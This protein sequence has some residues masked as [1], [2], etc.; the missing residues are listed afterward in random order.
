MAL[1][2]GQAEQDVHMV[3]PEVNNPGANNDEDE[4]DADEHT[5][6]RRRYVPLARGAQRRVANEGHPRSM[7]CVDV[8]R[9]EGG[10]RRRKSTTA[11]C[12]RQ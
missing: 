4:D 8:G 10:T 7:R 12:E 5:F 6:T 3:E 9:R 1:D 2:G 11:T